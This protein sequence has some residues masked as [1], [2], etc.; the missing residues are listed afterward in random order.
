MQLALTTRIEIQAGLDIAER[1]LP[2]DG[3]MKAPDRG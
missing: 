1:R 3:R 2:Q